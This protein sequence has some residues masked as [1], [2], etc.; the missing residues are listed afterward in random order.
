M[1]ATH[2][3]HCERPRGAYLLGIDRINN[4]IREYVM[5]NVVASCTRCNILKSDNSED[6]FIGK[7][8]KLKENVDK[9]VEERL[10]WL[11]KLMNK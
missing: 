6:F 11:D 1:M 9:S 4:T 2:C 10:D 7:M 5:G 3:H 8:A